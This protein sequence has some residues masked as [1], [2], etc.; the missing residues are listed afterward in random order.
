MTIMKGEFYRS[1]VWLDVVLH[2]TKVVPADDTV[3]CKIISGE[4]SSIGKTGSYM[5]ETFI[6]YYELIPEPVETRVIFKMCHSTHDHEEECVAFLLDVPARVGQVTLYAH[7][8]QHSE[9]PIGYFLSNYCRKATVE[10]YMDL[11]CELISLGYIP[12]VCKRWARR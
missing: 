12:T 3:F 8:G 7:V 1:K 4:E 11:K 10:E 5:L 6:A 2:V 9:G